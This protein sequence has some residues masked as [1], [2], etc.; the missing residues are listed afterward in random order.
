MCRVQPAATFHPGKEMAL[1]E[2]SEVV[3]LDILYAP[4][5][6]DARRY[7]PGLD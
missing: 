4:L 5:V 2:S 1:C 6:Y 3:G 7:V